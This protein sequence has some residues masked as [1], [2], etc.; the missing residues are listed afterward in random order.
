MDF[1]QF[2]KDMAAKHAEI[3]GRFHEDFSN[4]PLTKDVYGEYLEIM[5]VIC[6]D[7]SEDM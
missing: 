7:K 2:E 1:H 4:A 5:G 6:T 3:H